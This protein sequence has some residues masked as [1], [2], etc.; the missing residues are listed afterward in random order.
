MGAV[1]KILQQ[2]RLTL[3][4][5]GVD[6]HCRKLTAPVAVKVLGSKALG[7]VRGAMSK[8][9]NSASE[10]Q[11]MAV[12]REYLA[13]CMVEPA[14]GSETDPE[15]GIVSFEDLGNLGPELFAEI[16]RESGWM[17]QVEDFQRP[18]EGERG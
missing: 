8:G 16:M 4:V 3:T 10:E 7:I 6:F 11:N 15:A 2:N 1:D 13:A 17:G 5:G 12:I 9:D 14:L 18:S